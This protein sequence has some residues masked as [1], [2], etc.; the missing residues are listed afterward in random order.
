MKSSLS[1]SYHCCLICLTWFSFI[2]WQRCY[3]HKQY[4]NGLKF[5]KQILSN[6]KFAEHGGKQKCVGTVEMYLFCVCVFSLRLNRILTA[7]TLA[8][9]GLTLN[10]LGKKEE[11]YDLVR[12]GLRN[13]LKSH[14]CILPPRTRPAAVDQRR[15]VKSGCD[16]T[17]PLDATCCVE[18][19]SSQHILSLLLHLCLFFSHS[20]ARESSVCIRCREVL[21][22][23]KPR[24][25]STP[26]I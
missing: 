20:Q 13:D 16:A 2:P 25:K 24:V 12:R 15:L 22:Q 10:C 26:C 14:V 17:E 1:L 6:P 7:E 18:G 19:L 11:A 8:M 21:S 3:E 4:R 9:K 5:C 23:P